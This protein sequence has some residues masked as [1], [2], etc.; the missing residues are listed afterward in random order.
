MRILSDRHIS[1]EIYDDADI[2]LC[3]FVQYSHKVFGSTFVVYN[4][5]H[6]QH[7]AQECKWYG[8]LD[9][10]SAYEFESSLGQMK[11]L[12][13]APG[14]NLPQIV[15]RTLEKIVNFNTELV[16]EKAATQFLFE[17]HEFG[18]HDGLAGQALKKSYVMTL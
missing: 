9:D 3:N 16:K 12:L 15:A 5:H 2:L 18:L 4:I 7:L 13:H 17:S 6:L 10:F 11:Y 14:R 8:P 1:R